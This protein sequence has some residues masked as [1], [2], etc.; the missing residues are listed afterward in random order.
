MDNRILQKQ[1]KV[2]SVNESHEIVSNLIARMRIEQKKND[3]SGIYAKTQREMAYNSNKIEGSTLTPEQTASLFDT[4]TLRSDEDSVYRAKDIEEMTGHFAMFN[5]ML[6]T[7][8]EPLSEKL[9]KEYHYYLKAGVFE[10][11][12]NGYP[13]G[14]YKNRAN[15]VGNITTASPNQVPVFMA[16]LLTEYHKKQNKTLGDLARFHAAFEKIHP[17][18]DGNGR[19]GRMILFKECLANGIIPVIIRDS[20]KEEYY[21][22][23]NEAETKGDDKA[24][25][26]F[27]AKEQENYFQIVQNFLFDYSQEK[28]TQLPDQSLASFLNFSMSDMRER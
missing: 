3:R 5:H 28:E 4:G 6:A 19:T 20:E 7:W 21:H 12:A 23:L 10:D 16:E 13:V 25:T 24:I 1:L 8:E 27:F 9:I 15:I 22:A 11:M 17:F 26:M 2:L 14:E 18:Q